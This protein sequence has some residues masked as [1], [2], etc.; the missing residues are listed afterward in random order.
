MTTDVIDTSLHVSSFPTT[1]IGAGT[2]IGNCRQSGSVEQDVHGFFTSDGNPVQI[3]VGFKPLEVK[4]INETDTLIWEWQY[5]MAATH[6]LKT[7]GTPTVAIDTTSAI[8]VS[9][10]APNGGGN[11]IVTTSAAAAGTSKNIL[12]KIE[13]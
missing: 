2:I 8:V 9:E 10:P 1:Y 5:G 4:L 11:W 3:N 6:T 7:A 13:G 12:F